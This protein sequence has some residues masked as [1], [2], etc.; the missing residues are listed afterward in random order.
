MLDAAK[1]QS[2]LNFT[3][4]P[5]FFH[6]ETSIKEMKTS[7]DTVSFLRQTDRTS[8][9]LDWQPTRHWNQF[10]KIFDFCS[11]IDDFYKFDFYK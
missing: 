6:I 5:H 9:S 3:T 10:D 7:V 2:T 8:L 11:F 1:S 4:L